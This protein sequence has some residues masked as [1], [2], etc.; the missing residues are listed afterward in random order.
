[1]K[2]SRKIS[3]EQVE[4]TSFT[5]TTQLTEGLA[6]KAP[7]NHTHTIAQ[8]NGLEDALKYEN[9]ST[10]SSVTGT[11]SI[12]YN[13][14]IHRLTLTGNTTF[15]ESNLPPT[16]KGRTITL[17]VNGDFGVVFPSSFTTFLTGEYKGTATLNT[18]VIECFDD[19]RKVQISQPN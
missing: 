8:I 16:G 15:T 2:S 18:I 13:I 17:E 3:K 14:D 12:D 4:L 10:N 6:T 7:T 11:Y 9:V 19:F 5:T 1:M